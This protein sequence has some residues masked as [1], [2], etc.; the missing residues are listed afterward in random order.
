MATNSILGKLA[1]GETKLGVEERKLIDYLPKFMQDYS[2]MNAIMEAEQPEFDLVW[3]KADYVFADQFILDATDYGVMRW[4]S[5]LKITPKDTDTLD[6]RKFRILTL[7]NQELPYTLTKLKEALTTLC[8]ADGFVIDLQASNYHIDV[9]LA[10]GNHNKYQAVV[11][12]LTKMI[13]A[14]L[15]HKVDQ[16]Y[17]NHIVLAKLTHNQLASYSHEQLRN[18]VLN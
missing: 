18:E 3:V 15:T 5:M 4:E 14:N 11:E 16:M 12:L 2:E 9:K 10:V 17:N 6:E 13:P 7:L 1:L 8:G